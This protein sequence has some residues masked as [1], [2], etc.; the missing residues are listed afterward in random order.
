MPGERNSAEITLR[1]FVQARW[2]LLVLIVC[3]WA[4]QTISPA[5]FRW[6]VSWFPPPPE[7]TGTAAVVVL[8]VVGNLWM[9]MRVLGR[10]REVIEVLGDRL[11]QRPQRRDLR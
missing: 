2:V 3:G 9:R 5:M 4:A 7:P 8:L 10:G 1:L 6:V 11:L